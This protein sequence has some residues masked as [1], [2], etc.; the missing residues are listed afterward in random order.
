MWHWSELRKV[1]IFCSMFL[2]ALQAWHSLLG[3]YYSDVAH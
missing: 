3:S 2:G 1:D